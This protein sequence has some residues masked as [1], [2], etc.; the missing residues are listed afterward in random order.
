M[1]TALAPLDDIHDCDTDRR[2][3]A[4]HIA[5]LRVGRAAW[6]D[7]DRLCVVRNISPGGLM[8]ECLNPP[9]AGE[10]VLIELRSDK[11][12]PGIVRWSEAGKAG[13]Q[14][15]NEVSVQQ[16]L[17]EERSP[18]L[19]VR[20]RLPRFVRGGSVRLIGEGEPFQGRVIDI[21][22]SGLSC[23]TDQPLRSG[24]PIVVALETV[25]A[26]PAEIRWMRG[27]AVGIRFEKPL[28][29][30]AFQSWLDQAPRA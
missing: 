28:P 17:K 14:F 19:R 25:G 18:L 22:M 12:M 3:G 11:Q 26:T 15:D 16:M 27:D 4:R 29:W 13:L 7:E 21:S 30:R 6:G 24:E 8:F 5:V 2:I 9:P 1:N 23:R 10:R 20:P